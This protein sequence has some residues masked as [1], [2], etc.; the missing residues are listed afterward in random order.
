MR[1][2]YL[3][4]GKDDDYSVLREMYKGVFDATTKQV[5]TCGRL[6]DSPCHDHCAYFNIVR[7]KKPEDK[8]KPP[9]VLCGAII[10]GELAEPP[11]GGK[12]GET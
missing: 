3:G 8:G 7:P 1:K 5:L 10:I 4:H 11:E 2:V 6:S 12:D 9:F